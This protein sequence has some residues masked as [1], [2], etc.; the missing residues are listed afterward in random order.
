MTQLSAAVVPQ[1]PDLAGK[2]ALVTGGSKGIG[3]Q[4]RYKLPWPPQPASPAPPAPP[5]KGTRQ[6]GF[7]PLWGFST[8]PAKFLP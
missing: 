6:S 4:G 5:D 7:P 3:R 1:Y 2:V 8:L